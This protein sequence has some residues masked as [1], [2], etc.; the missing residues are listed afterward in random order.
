MAILRYLKY[1]FLFVVALGLVLMAMANRETVVLEVIPEDLAAWFGIQYAIEMPL[2]VVILGGVMLGILVGFVWEWLREHRHRAEA[3]TQKRTA[4]ALEREVQT[5]KGPARDSQ[6]EI[7]AL[8][9]GTGT[10]R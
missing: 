9:D 8:V 6:D 1:T 2:F 3:K 4:Q 5:L 7:L 10:A